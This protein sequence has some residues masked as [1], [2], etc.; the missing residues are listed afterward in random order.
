MNKFGNKWWLNNIV[1]VLGLIFQSYIA[2]SLKLEEGS[3]GTVNW[4]LCAWMS[5]PYWI[6]FF[7]NLHFNRTASARIT[8][9]RA[10]YIIVIFSNSF[11]AMGI[12]SRDA[13]A[14]L[15]FLFI[16]VFGIMFSLVFFIMAISLNR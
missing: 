8:V 15:L 6:L 12:L 4:G 10:I 11:Y 14:G 7:A 3:M 5:I 2:L 16:P 1:L 9:T 13:Q